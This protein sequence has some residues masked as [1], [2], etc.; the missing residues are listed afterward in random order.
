MSWRERST[1]GGEFVGEVY[2]LLRVDDAFVVDHPHGFTWWAGDFATTISTD[3]GLFRQST[4]TYRVT[5][6]TE[7]LKG[8]GHMRE[9][10]LALEHEMDNCSFSGPYYNQDTDTFRLF[11]SVYAADE[12]AVWL[13]KTFAAAVALQVAEANE[14]GH[15]L[16]HLLHAVPATSSHPN[17]GL[18]DHASPIVSSAYG[19]F[20]GSGQNASRWLDQPEWKQSSWVMERE[21]SS[22]EVELGQRM[23]GTYPWNCGE[24]HIEVQIRTDE[25]H[26]KVGNGLH[27]TLTIPMEISMEGIGHLVLE[28]NALERDEYKR[29][30]TLG[31]WCEHDGKLAYR[32]FV[33]N[34]LYDH[35]MLH[36]LVVNF[37]TRALWADEFFMQ[38]MTEAQ[39][40]GSL[41]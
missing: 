40:R 21:A 31:S 28:L 16:A 30:H 12:N 14:M 27:L 23:V 36:D 24:G 15:R 7:F 29:C 18:R 33:P 4:V 9:L 19:F 38:K 20:A 22:F 41:H 8:R 3:E 11:C 13:R 35:R 17:A 34:C 10:A 6:E 32:T 39:S 1:L 25:P 2:D 37:S 5:A 26:P